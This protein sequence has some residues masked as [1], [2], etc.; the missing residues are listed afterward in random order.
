VALLEGRV[1]GGGFSYWCPGCKTDHWVRVE[2]DRWAPG[3]RPMWTWNGSLDAPTFG[4]SVKHFY[5]K[6][7]GEGKPAI[8]VTTCHYFITDGVIRYCGDCP[9]ELN[10][11]NVRMIDIEAGRSGKYVVEFVGPAPAPTPAPATTR[12][13]PSAA[14]ARRGPQA[15]AP[16]PRP[17]GPPRPVPAPGLTLWAP[18]RKA[19]PPQV[20]SRFTHP[21][22]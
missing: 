22:G 4:P 21:R 18:R 16:P 14:P 20:V 10:G 8:Q 13:N 19:R 7:G 9:H 1:G 15:L 17:P 5:D 11:R 3:T 2:S 12:P 6:P